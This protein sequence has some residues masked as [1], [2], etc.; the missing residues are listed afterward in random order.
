M[1]QRIT[2]D[3]FDAPRNAAI[4]GMEQDIPSYLNTLAELGMSNAQLAQV[5]Q[6][7]KSTIWAWRKGGKPR[8]PVGTALALRGLVATM[9][10]GPSG[11]DY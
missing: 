5:F 7:D 10:G 1:E 4:L 9:G 8:N 3:L 11:G 2:C 6:V